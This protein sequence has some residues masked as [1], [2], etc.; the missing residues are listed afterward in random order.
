MSLP[1]TFSYGNE[2]NLP[3]NPRETPSKNQPDLQLTGI[4]RYHRLIAEA[5]Y[6]RDEESGLSY[7]VESFHFS[8]CLN[9]A[10]RNA[11]SQREARFYREL[12]EQ[13]M[14]EKEIIVD[15]QNLRKFRR[16]TPST[17][18]LIQRDLD[19]AFREG[20]DASDSPFD[21]PLDYKETLNDALS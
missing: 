8:E 6:V 1:G 12:L 18:D 15:H 7:M 21:S 10:S 19:R 2:E 14:M 3:E 13:V 4:K 9:R 5:V 16:R 20:P 11:R 17:A